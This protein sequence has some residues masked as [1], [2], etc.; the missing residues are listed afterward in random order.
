MAQLSISDRLDQLTGKLSELSKAI[1]AAYDELDQA[2]GEWLPK[3]DAVAETLREE[4]REQG[5]KSDP[6]EHTVLSAARARYPAEYSRWKRAKRDVQKFEEIA[7]NRRS[8]VSS[9]QT[10]VRESG[11]ERKTGGQG[12]RGLPQHAQRRAAAA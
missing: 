12:T 5:R 7:S 6:A 8:E 10:Q 1:Y 9:L 3:F 2:E 4:G 11:G